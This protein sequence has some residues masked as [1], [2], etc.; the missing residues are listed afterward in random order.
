[1]K[2]YR[3]LLVYAYGDSEE[4]ILIKANS[5][6]EAKAKLL[7]FKINLGYTEFKVRDKD[8]EEIS[9]NDSGICMI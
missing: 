3:Y 8:I 9:F 1:M 6:D 7:N 5:K 4:E 2:L